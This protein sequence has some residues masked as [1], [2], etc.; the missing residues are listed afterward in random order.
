MAQTT[1]EVW[2]SRWTSTRRSI[3]PEVVDNFFEDYR[4]LAMHRRRGLQMTSQGGKEIHV[5]LESGGGSAESFDRYDSL[6]KNP[7]DPFESGFFKRRYYA[8]PVVLADTEDWENSGPEQVFNL[9]EALGN[10]A[11]NSLLK[12]INEDIFSAQSG[13][14]ILGYQDHMADAA[15]ATVGGI[16]SST[17]TFW[18]SQRDTSA[19][20]FTSQTVTDIF[21]GI[22]TWNNVLD[23]C[24]IQGGTIRQILTTYSICRAYREA[25]SSQAYARTTTQDAKGIGG[26]QMPDFYTAEVI[27][28]NDCPALHSYF[29]NTQNIKLNVLRQAN[30]RKTP[31]VS[32]QSNGQLAQL[33]YMVAGVQLTNNNRRRSGVATAI[34]GS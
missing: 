2:D 4:A 9:L 21:D 7:I 17:S 10:N 31:F 19:V 3:Q 22:A 25:L 23:L 33:A 28:D 14:N 20:T 34:T 32:M 27:P 11:M 15:G 24:Q 26:S 30:F 1:S 5:I 16:N 6:N 29:P 8:V 12:A 13:K 18:E